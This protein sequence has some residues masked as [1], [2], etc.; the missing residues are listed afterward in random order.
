MLIIKSKHKILYKMNKLPRIS[1]SVALLLCIMALSGLLR[2]DGV[3]D[4]LDEESLLPKTI[5]PLE[6][7]MASLGRYGNYQVNLFNGLPQISFTL[8]EVKSGDLSQPIVLSYHGGGVKVSDDAGWVGLGWDLFYGGAITRTVYG[9]PDEEENFANTPNSQSIRNQMNANPTDIYNTYFDALAEGFNYSYMQDQYQFSCLAGNGMFVL[10]TTNSPLLI[11]HQ[12]LSI[13]FSGVTKQINTADQTSFLFRA[14]DETSNSGKENPY[15]SSWSIDQILS[16]DRK[17]TIRYN[18]QSDGYISNI[19]KRK[20]DGYIYNISPE[21]NTY[22]RIG[23]QSS[24]SVMEVLAQKPQ[25]IFFKDG[26]LEFILSDRF[27]IYSSRNENNPINQ[28]LKKLDRIIVYRKENDGMYNPIKQIM[29]YYSYFGTE[30]TP[31]SSDPDHLRL[32]LDKVTE[33]VGS[34]EHLT[35]SFQYH[36]GLPPKSSYSTDHWGYYNGQTNSTPI[37]SFQINS[38]YIE[39]ATKSSSSTSM[40]AGSLSKITYP[41]GGSTTF[42]WEANDVYTN[43][44]IITGENNQTYSIKENDILGYS[45]LNHATSGDPSPDDPV[46][47]LV[48]TISI[49]K[50]QTIYGSYRLYR[51]NTS[52]PGH[53]DYDT[54]ALSITDNNNNDIIFHVNSLSYP[55]QQPLVLNLTAGHSYSVKIEANCTNVKGDLSFDYV[56]LPESGNYLVGG[57][58]I[59]SIVNKDIGE[60]IVSTKKYSYK[61]PDNPSIS[62][63]YAKTDFADVDY[64]TS[65]RSYLQWGEVFECRRQITEQ[66]VYY[67]DPIAGIYS[68]PVCYQYVKEVDYS[69]GMDNGYTLSQFSVYPDSNPTKDILISNEWKRGDLVQKEVFLNDGTYQLIKKTNYKYSLHPNVNQQATGFKMYRLL[70]KVET[71]CGIS[72]GY[73]N[74]ITL[75]EIYEPFNFYYE[76]AWKHLDTT[77][78]RN[79]YEGTEVVET[80]NYIYNNTFHCKPS[81][82]NHQLSGKTLSVENTYMGDTGLV[83]NRKEKLDNTVTKE[84]DII[85]NSDLQPS[86]FKEISSNQVDF[87]KHTYTYDAQKNLIELA[88]EN[89]IS[90]VFIWGY[91]QNQLVAK[92]TS[93]NIIGVSPSIR[94]SISS[95]SFDQSGSK[96]AIDNDVRFLRSTLSNYVS[97]NAFQVTIFTYTPLKGMTSQTDPNGKTLY[98]EYDSFGRMKAMTDHNGKLLKN[99]QYRYIT[100]NIISAQ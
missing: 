1:K 12:P 85:Y 97:N 98:F 90:T 70:G 62:S 47:I 50:T 16:H 31:T 17:D 23:L 40:L 13:D 58:R 63:G 86:I 46:G 65:Q 84:E 10:N 95:H 57:L 94:N 18:Y 72:Y 36:N 8:F 88:K 79:Y 37:V 45:L 19:N 96:L 80:S 42:N 83:T 15:V 82:I 87:N 7:T 20:Y 34:E 68:S 26:K 14:T 35:A 81:L 5:K 89:D 4:G 53:N 27:D 52:D 59:E 2:A 49:N 22:S 39:G 100:D 38:Q 91:D 67:S 64:S 24:T 56:Q 29:F 9:N 43:N 44:T 41:T 73:E 51:E 54:G 61:M 76:S 48:E 99:Y 75:N 30:S 74:P 33:L 25:Y 11:P 60:T 71:P 55:T 3:G 21:G 92:I 93:G 28:A 78:V 66:H 6:P 32:R 69:G 77:I